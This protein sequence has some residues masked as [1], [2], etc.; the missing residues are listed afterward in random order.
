MNTTLNA[1]HDAAYDLQKIYM[2]LNTSLSFVFS[3]FLFCL[4]VLLITCFKHVGL[5]CYI[6]QDLCYV[7]LNKS[8]LGS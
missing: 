1:A 6:L 8:L 2:L 7:L 5:I 4:F 3:L